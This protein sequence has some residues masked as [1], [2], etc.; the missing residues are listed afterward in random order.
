[1][2][3]SSEKRRREKLLLGHCFGHSRG[4]GYWS[5]E[6]KREKREKEKSLS[7]SRRTLPHPENGRNC[8]WKEKRKRCRE[9]CEQRR[10]EKWGSQRREKERECV[11]IWVRACCLRSWNSLFYLSCPVAPLFGEGH[12]QQQWHPSTLPLRLQSVSLEPESQA[13]WLTS[14]SCW[15]MASWKRS[16]CYSNLS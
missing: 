11:N 2:V 4:G 7:D 12:R 10:E 5:T 9:M 1:M 16:K 13:N 3:N 15:Q 8:Q 6:K 14:K